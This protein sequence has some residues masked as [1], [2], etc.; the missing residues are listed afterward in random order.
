MI[1]LDKLPELDKTDYK[2]LYIQLGDILENCIR[3]NKFASANRF[4]SEKELMDRYGLSRATVRQALQR[5]EAAGL[6]HKVRGKGTFLADTRQIKHIGDLFQSIEDSMMQQGFTVKNVLLES[7]DIYPPKN[8]ANQLKLSSKKK[9]RLIR[10]LKLV[11]ESPLG[12]EIRLIPMDLADYLSP[13]D[14]ENKSIFPIINSIP[15]CAIHNIK[16]NIE[17]RMV[18]DQEANEMKIPLKTTLLVRKGVYHGIDGRPIMIS[19]LAFLPVLLD[20]EYEFNKDGH[21]WKLVKAR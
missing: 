4:P 21:N 17:A 5:L 20:L 14:I 8:L 11:D 7:D 15:G 16:Y 10:R 6:V 9:A 1:D 13:T 19:Q 2:P 12:I 18:S 3:S